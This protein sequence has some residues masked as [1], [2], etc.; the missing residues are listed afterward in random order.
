M[1]MGSSQSRRV[2]GS[3]FGVRAAC[4]RFPVA[5]LLAK[6]RSRL[7]IRKRQQ[8]AAVQGRGRLLS[9]DAHLP[10]HQHREQPIAE[11]GEFLVW[12]LEV[13]DLLEDGG[14]DGLGES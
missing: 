3:W 10:V 13:L 6:T 5:S 7:R 11:G 9:G 1:S 8:A 12:L 4:C 2:V 14:V